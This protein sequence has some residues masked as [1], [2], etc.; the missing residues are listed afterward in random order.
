MI[1]ATGA[2]HSLNMISSVA[3]QGL[4]LFSTYTGS[5][6]G[7]RFIEFC[8]KLIHDVVRLGSAVALRWGWQPHPAWGAR[9]PCV[10][11]RAATTSTA[12][13]GGARQTCSAV[14]QAYRDEVG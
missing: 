7:A 1:K 5:L 3:A 10:V 13:A 14:R 11:G 12:V 4:L 6:T 2:R 9:F 8:R